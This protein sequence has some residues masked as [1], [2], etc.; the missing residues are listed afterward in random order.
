MSLINKITLIISTKKLIKFF[1]LLEQG[2]LVESSVGC[3]LRDFICG[4]LGLEEEYLRNRV[5]TIFLDHD[6]VDNLDTARI[7]AG[8]TLALSAAMPGLAGATLRKGGRFAVMRKQISCDG[9]ADSESGEQT[10]VTVK[11]FN[12]VAE[13]LGKNRL[14]NGIRIQCASF[15]Q[16][17]D[18]H[19]Q[20]LQPHI[21]SARLDG[22]AIEAHTLASLPCREED[23][24]WCQILPSE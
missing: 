22:K 3:P 1:Q 7:R 8:S 17:L 24:W 4:R 12:T 5:Q 20:E 19:G 11:F 2:F 6:P 15:I 13:E 14:K 21:R 10:N 18:R 23:V 9:A 16:F